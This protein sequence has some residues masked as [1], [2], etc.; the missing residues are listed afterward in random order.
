MESAVTRRGRTVVPARLRNRYHMT[1]PTGIPPEHS[2]SG[3][4]RSIRSLGSTRTDGAGPSEGRGGLG[5]K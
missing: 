5:M 1:M 2:Y 3:S 4:I